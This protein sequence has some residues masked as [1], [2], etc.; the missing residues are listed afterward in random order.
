MLAGLASPGC[1]DPASLSCLDG[2]QRPDPRGGH[3]RVPNLTAVLPRLTGEWA[4]RLPP[5]AL[6]AWC[7]EIG[8]PA[9][10]DRGLTPVTTRPR[11]LWPMR[12]GNTA[13]RHRPHLSGVRFRATASGQARATRPLARV[14]AVHPR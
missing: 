14:Q 9:W 12:H 11:F 4:T 6:L 2:G 1:W 13:C 7:R 8:A 5:D 3:Q 10:R